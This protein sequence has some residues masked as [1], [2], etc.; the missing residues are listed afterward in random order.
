MKTAHYSAIALMTLMLSACA[1]SPAT[2]EL[3]AE[4]ARTIPTCSGDEDCQDKWAIAR[5]W[6]VKNS[7]FAIRSESE[8]RIMSTSNIISQS[9]LGVTVDRSPTEGGN[10]QITVSVDC[11]SAYGCPDTLETMVDFN[12][13]LNAA[14][15]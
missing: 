6:V 14:H 13:T 15:P 3:R 4:Y 1:V 2:L 5:A 7:D 8:T 12:R 11:F 10:Y 9:G